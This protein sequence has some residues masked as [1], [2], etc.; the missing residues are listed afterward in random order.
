[1]TFGYDVDTHFPTLSGGRAEFNHIVTEGPFV[2][3]HQRM[4]TPFFLSNRSVFPT[5]YHMHG[6]DMDSDYTLIRSSQGNEALS[7]EHVELIGNDVEADFILFW[8]NCVAISE[9]QSRIRFAMHANLG[10]SLPDR[11]RAMIASKQAEFID[12]LQGYIAKNATAMEE[13]YTRKKD[14]ME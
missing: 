3:H 8:V 6:D 2:T 10:G 9:T 7:E 1:M 4:H 11:A 12:M 13:S 14:L 5:T